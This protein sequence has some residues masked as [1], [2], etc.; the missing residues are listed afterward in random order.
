VPFTKAALEI[1]GQTYPLT[2]KGGGRFERAIAG[3]QQGATF[4]VDVYTMDG[5]LAEQKVY[6]VK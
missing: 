5:N 1:K 4:K 3:L 2:N 6:R